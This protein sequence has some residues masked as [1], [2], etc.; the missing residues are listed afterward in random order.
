MTGGNFSFSVYTLYHDLRMTYA[1][2]TSLFIRIEILYDRTK[3]T[4]KNR[5]RQTSK[6]QKAVCDSETLFHEACPRRWHIFNI[7]HFNEIW[8]QITWQVKTEVRLTISYIIIAY[9]GI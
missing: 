6:C 3:T 4:I 1:K 2:Y 7:K 8:P 5:T 9:N